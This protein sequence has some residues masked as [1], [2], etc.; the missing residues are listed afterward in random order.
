MRTMRAVGGLV[1]VAGHAA[2]GDPAYEMVAAHT[3]ASQWSACRHR[4]AASATGTSPAVFAARTHGRP[5]AATTRRRRETPP[6]QQDGR[7]HGVDSAFFQHA[8][9]SLT[10][11]AGNGGLST[12]RTI[13]ADGEAVDAAVRR[14]RSR[15]LRPVVAVP[16]CFRVDG[17]RP[18]R[19]RHASLP[20]GSWR[21]VTPSRGLISSTSSPAASVRSSGAPTSRSCAPV[22]GP[23][24]SRSRCCR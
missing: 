16:D 3:T 19:Q 22:P 24:R 17:C 9:A 2:D 10:P 5:Q 7:G 14:R 13:G 4:V 12:R 23:T 18:R 8:L 15:N 21:E 20:D 6:I 1:L 11:A